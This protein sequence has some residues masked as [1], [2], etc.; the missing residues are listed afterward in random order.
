MSTRLAYASC[1]VT[2]E[3]LPNGVKGYDG[4]YISYC[5]YQAHYGSDTTALVLAG[6]VFFI[7]NGDHSGDLIKAAEVS[8]LSGC[9]EAFLERAAQ[10]NPLS[11]HRMALGLSD[12]PFGLQ[13]T[14]RTLFTADQIESF[15]KQLDAAQ[16]INKAET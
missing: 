11:E 6:R 15:L 7:L 5:R 10:A 16:R 8:G 4:F 13:E 1:P 12:D 14:I 9:M 2:N 3:R